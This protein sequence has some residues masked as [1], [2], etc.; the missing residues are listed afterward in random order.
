MI[1][2][3]NADR[4]PIRIPIVVFDT[5]VFDCR[6]GHPRLAVNQPDHV[7][8]TR[9]PRRLDEP[10]HLTSGHLCRCDP[11]HGEEH[12]QIE[13]LR[14]HRVRPGPRRDEPQIL[15]QQRLTQPGSL[16]LDTAQ[17]RHELHRRTPVRQ[18]LVGLASG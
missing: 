11:D 12:L 10:Q 17:A 14:Q 18:A 1:R 16:S 7:A 8:V 9:L 13:R 2:L 6:R 3:K 5:W 4:C 15:I